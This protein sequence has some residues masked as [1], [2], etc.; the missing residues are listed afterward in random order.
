M[1]DADG[2]KTGDFLYTICNTPRVAAKSFAIVYSYLRPADAASSTQPPKARCRQVSFFSIRTSKPTRDRCA[3]LN[4]STH[5]AGDEVFQ[6]VM[7]WGANSLAGAGDPAQAAR[8]RA[9]SWAASGGRPILAD[10]SLC[11]GFAL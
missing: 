11:T 4:G 10:L 5:S 1:Q 7:E 9:V 6:H 8:A 3:V 2:C